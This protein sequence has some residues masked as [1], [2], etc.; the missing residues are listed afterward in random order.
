MARERSAGAPGLPENSLSCGWVAGA[1]SAKPRRRVPG[2]PKTPAPAA[3]TGSECERGGA[4][5]SASF[6]RRSTVDHLVGVGVGPSRLQVLVEA[7]VA[8]LLHDAHVELP[9][10]LLGDPELLAD[11]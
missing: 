2:L 6:F 11:L 5:G 7:D 8:Q 9:H 4:T 10:A 1:E 3:P